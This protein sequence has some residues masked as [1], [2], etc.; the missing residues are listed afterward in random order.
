MPG[1]SPAVRR[2]RVAT[3]A[4]IKPP[5]AVS[6]SHIFGKQAPNAC[7]AGEDAGHHRADE[8]GRRLLA[9]PS[10][11]EVKNGFVA[12]RPR[13]REW[14]GENSRLGRDRQERRGGK[15]GKRRRYLAQAAAAEDQS[16]AR[17]IVA[18]LQPALQAKLAYQPEG[19]GR[20]VEKPVGTRFTEIA[21]DDVGSDVTA[22]AGAS[23]Q[24]DH[25]GRRVAGLDR[26]RGRQA[27]DAPS[28]DGDADH[29]GRATPAGGAIQG[30]PSES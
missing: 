14:L 18:R 2:D 16:P 13:A 8:H 6:I 21:V 30:R 26:L 11:G 4:R 15:T 23:F 9:D 7:V 28:D 20:V 22:G 17:R 24:H 1:A 3:S 5:C 27:G 29:A 19:I 10:G 25:I 12:G